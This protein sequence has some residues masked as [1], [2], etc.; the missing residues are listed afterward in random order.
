MANTIT[1]GRMTFTSP[2][3][4][5]FSSVQTG[6]RNSLDREVSLSG[7]FV[8]DTVAAAKVLRDE[9]ISMGNSSLLLPFTY[10]GDDKFEGYCELDGVNVNSNKL[11]TGLFE[12]SFTLIIKG[13]VSEMLFES[14][15]SGSLL[16]NSHSVTTG[17]TV[18]APWHA[19]PVNSFNYNHEKAPTDAIRATS[20]GNVVFFYDPDLRD[21]AA[22]WLVNPADY[23]KGA[24]RVIINNTTRTGYLSENTPTGVTL[25]NGIIQ[26]T[27]GANTDQS[28]F[29]IKFYDN[30]SFVSERTIAI[31]SGSSG[32]EYKLWQTA[33]IIRN[34]PHECVV[35]F[36]T[37][38]DTN[39]DGRLIVDATVKRGAHHIGLNISQGP[40]AD[41]AANSRVN[42]DVVSGGGTFTT[43]TGYIVENAID[44]AGQKFLMGSPQGFTADTS[45][46][47]IHLS[48]T[49]FKTFIGYVYNASN[50]ASIDTADAV[51]DQYLESMFENVRLVR[52]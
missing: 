13:R 18:Y 51:R 33:Q 20:E 43:G 29:T 16:T 3:S 50:P 6:R 12:Y 19:V 10:T 15:M 22:Q 25:S 11:A 40:T 2:Q 7:Q 5:D 34:E 49:Q 28:R 41:R 8:A 32:T 38:S 39:G 36:A 52:A 24:C 21:A 23:Y 44:N 35:R 1:V 26:L 31:T 47:L 42:L 14:N 9:L 37:Y 27:S 46:K 4:I 30:G 17:T 45:N 48:S